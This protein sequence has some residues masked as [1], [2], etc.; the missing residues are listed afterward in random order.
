MTAGQ[1]FARLVTDVVSRVPWLWPVFRRPLTA[2]FDRIAPSWSAMRSQD[3]MEP[4]HAALD[5]L[6]RPPGRI[7]DLGTGTGLA[8]VAAARRFPSA[9]V[10]GIDVSPR[11][12]DEARRDTP[13]DVASRVRYEV[14]DAAEMAF[15][16]PYDLVVLANMI[17]FFD[18]LQQLVAPGG[19][20]VFTFSR[21]DE[22]P[23]YVPAERLRREL[24]RRGF[25]RFDEVAAGTGTALV[26]GRPTQK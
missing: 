4:L 9:E 2:M 26:A 14:A 13:A 10:V 21:G 5:L 19:H 3:A 17:P 20:A 11:M 24:E 22:T 25:D 1:R 23:I 12:I 16:E 6:P 15:S 7:L 8:A 18:E